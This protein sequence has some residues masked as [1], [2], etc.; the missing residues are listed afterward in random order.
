M[1]KKNL[2]NMFFMLILGILFAFP[3]LLKA[4][5]YGNDTSKTDSSGMYNKGNNG[6][7]KDSSG[8][9]SDTMGYKS[10]SSMNDSYALNN[11]SS[12]SS[13]NGNNNKDAAI[14]PAKDL[15]QKLKKDVNLND[16]QTVKIKSILLQYEADTYNAKGDQ[17]DAKEATQDAQENIADVLTDSQKSE[18]RNVKSEWWNSVDKELNLSELNQNKNNKQM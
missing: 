17:E 16:D 18:W 15:S 9:K 1:K 7:Y 12:Y 14:N 11:S 3:V 6:N 10:N 13:D 2:A 8:S 5:N 4:Q